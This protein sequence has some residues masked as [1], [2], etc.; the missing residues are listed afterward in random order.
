MKMFSKRYEK[1]ENYNIKILDSIEN[2][3]NI[4]KNNNYVLKK[5]EY[6]IEIY[7]VNKNEN[8]SKIKKLE[9]ITDY[10]II[11]DKNGNRKI[12]LKNTEKQEAKIYSIFLAHE[13]LYNLGY[14]ELFYIN[15]DIYHYEKEEDE[16]IFYF[17][18][19]EV[20]D[21]GCFLK[22]SNITLN[23][24]KKFIMKLKELGINADDKNLKIDN[25][26]QELDKV[27]FKRK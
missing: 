21:Q 3:N 25:V 6:D 5:Y 11:K 15:K 27:L 18:V 4:L 14:Y 7:M 23:S 20:K 2:I 13:L 19:L 1:N 17:E 8:F 16:N 22:I 24:L 10:A 12:I 26:Q 9:D